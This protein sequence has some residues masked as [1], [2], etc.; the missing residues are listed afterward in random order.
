MSSPISRSSYSSTTSDFLRDQ[1]EAT[2][3]INKE[4]RESSDVI[5]C[6]Q[7][8]VRESVKLKEDVLGLESQL[9]IAKETINLQEAAFAFE[10]N[11]YEKEIQQLRDSEAQLRTKLTQ[12]ETNIRNNTY[13]Y[14]VQVKLNQNAEK[15]KNLT[16]KNE[17]LKAK[18]KELD[19]N[20]KNMQSKVDA[21]I[22][23]KHQAEIESTKNKESLNSQQ[24]LIKQQL[25]DKDKEIE[26]L[27]GLL[28]QQEATNKEFADKNNELE[29]VIAQLQQKISEKRNKHKS[30]LEQ[31][32]TSCNNLQEQVTQLEDEKEKMSEL[33]KKA[34]SKLQKQKSHIDEMRSE[35]EQSKDSADLL[36][37]LSTSKQDNETL[38]QRIA[39]LKNALLQSKT[40]LEHVSVER[41][42]IADLLGVETD[43][44]DK[45]WK[46]IK[47]KV[48]EL[49]ESD[50]VINGLQVQNN[51]LRTRLSAAL[52]EIKVRRAD[53]KRT[54]TLE[55]EVQKN[56]N[57]EETIKKLKEDSEI[58]SALLQRYKTRIL[59]AQT[60]YAQSNKLQ[61]DITDLHTSIFGAGVTQLRSIILSIIFS[62]RFFRSAEWD[63]ITDPQGLHCFSARPQMS[64]AKKIQEIREKF[65]E[66]SNDLLITKQSEVDYA[67]KCTKLLTS[68]N[69][70]KEKHQTMTQENE[71]M[72]KR[73]AASDARS[74]ELQTELGTLV[75]KEDFKEAITKSRTLQKANETM[76]KEI[77]D[78]KG[79]LNDKAASE[80]IVVDKSQKLAVELKDK[81]VVIEEYTNALEEK[82]KNIKELNALIKEK[83]KEILSLERIV[84][85]YRQNENAVQSSYTCLAV[86][87]QN[88][89]QKMNVASPRQFN[90]DTDLTFS[91]TINPAFLGQ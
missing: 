12:M 53:E 22:E 3:A 20:C 49:M 87:N 73:V 50:R 64:A 55:I 81:E 85:R 37:Q 70:M 32:V 65:T 86:E 62:K 27:N 9:K 79:K 88:L 26:R 30:L 39:T 66:V 63:A 52:E 74:K 2:K 6:L 77:L 8:K 10:K 4:S 25:A 42:A 23:E 54:A 19:A 38:K 18:N 69:E 34:E 1:L 51:K 45:D 33:L 29:D 28:I 61:K 59:F 72:K 14:E 80:Q 40:L 44:I 41:D 76:Q 21:L 46:S 83:T 75:S 58:S 71:E 90:T 47:D 35:L 7:N 78:L 24:T 5:D 36:S 16:E 68:I 91:A 31:S 84:Q 57:L 15:I 56:Q 60:I 43:D 13:T 89:M 11:E 17:K 82:D 48:S 67:E